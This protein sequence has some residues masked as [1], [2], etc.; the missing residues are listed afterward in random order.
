VYILSSQE[1]HKVV[2]ELGP[3]YI[4]QIITD[5]GSNYKKACKMITHKFPIVFQPCLAHMINLMLKAV[6]EFSEHK[7]VILAGRRICRCLYNHN[8][9]HAM[10]RTAIGGELVSGMQL[11]LAP[12]TCSWKACIVEGTSS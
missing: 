3:E 7:A 11:D 2:V 8:K 12:T 1:I 4:L 10:M 6:G 9:L 5:N